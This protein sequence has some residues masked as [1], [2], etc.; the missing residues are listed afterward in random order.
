M[1]YVTMD[2]FKYAIETMRPKRE[3]WDNAQVSCGTP[4]DLEI[5]RRTRCLSVGDRIRKALR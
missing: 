4:Q 2:A 1:A 5:F 3:D